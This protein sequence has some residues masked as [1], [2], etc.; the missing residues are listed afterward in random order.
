M[1]TKTESQILADSYKAKQQKGLIDVKFYV[2]NPE[3]KEEVCA[4]INRL[5]KAI[6]R[7]EYKTLEFGDSRH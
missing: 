6:D 7:E 2:K 1:S 3:L 5:D 4:E